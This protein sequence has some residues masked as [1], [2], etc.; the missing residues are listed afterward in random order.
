MGKEEA[1]KRVIDL[2]VSYEAHRDTDDEVLRMAYI[3]TPRT[4][5]RRRC[6]SSRLEPARAETDGREPPPGRCERHLQ[7]LL[8]TKDTRLYDISVR[9][10][11][12]E[13]THL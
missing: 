2:H 11:A 9:A 5:A 6:A 4:R 7:Q 13:E 3:R 1:F 12:E 8:P 10:H